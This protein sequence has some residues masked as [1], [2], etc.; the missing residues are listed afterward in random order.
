MRS[1]FGIGSREMC[2]SYVLSLDNWSLHSMLMYVVFVR[3]RL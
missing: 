3:N 2:V 1:D